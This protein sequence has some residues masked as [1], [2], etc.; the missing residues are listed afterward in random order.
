MTKGLC[1]R[2]MFLDSLLATSKSVKTRKGPRKRGLGVR[3]VVHRGL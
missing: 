2:I 1:I 3:F